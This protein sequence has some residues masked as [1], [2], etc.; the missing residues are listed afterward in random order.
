MFQQCQKWGGLVSKMVRYYVYFRHQ[1]LKYSLQLTAT[2]STN[3]IYA[4]S[5]WR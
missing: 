3:K 5:T 4:E 2:L 1:R